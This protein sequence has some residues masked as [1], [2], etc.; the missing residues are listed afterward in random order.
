MQPNV[1]RYFWI[2]PVN[3]FVIELF[4]NKICQLQVGL[5]NSNS[6]N[7]NSPLFRN[8]N[9]RVKTIHLGFAL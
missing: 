6:V 2:I 1:F 7:T 3:Q 4:P 8:Q 5:A 9:L